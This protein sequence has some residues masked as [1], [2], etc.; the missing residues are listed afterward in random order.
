MNRTERKITKS[1]TFVN[2]RHSSRKT[3]DGF[4]Y[5]KVSSQSFLC[6]LESFASIYLRYQTS[7]RRFSTNY[8]WIRLR[9][10]S[11]RFIYDPNTN[12]YIK[13]NIEYDFPPSHCTGVR[14]CVVS[15][16][17]LCT[18]RRASAESRNECIVNWCVWSND[19]MTV[20]HNICGQTAWTKKKLIDLV[21]WI[22]VRWQTP[23]D[24]TIGRWINMPHLRSSDNEIRNA[25]STEADL[26]MAMVVIFSNEYANCERWAFVLCPKLVPHF[27]ND[28]RILFVLSLHPIE[29]SF[30]VV[31]DQ[32]RNANARLF[33][34]VISSKHF[35][36]ASVQT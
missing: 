28:A 29:A 22:N 27:Q 23:D 25:E 17:P 26:P 21:F 7:N 16:I 5:A 32:K 19:K 36:C 35:M 34:N 30:P 1:W 31:V 10:D 12:V 3:K 18:V 11:I 8:S 4:R 24:D 33:L 20:I 9:A 2:T 14:Y 6:R 13:W 15:P